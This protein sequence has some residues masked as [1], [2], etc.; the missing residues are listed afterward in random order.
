MLKKVFYLFTCFV[1]VA[2]AVFPT[3]VAAQGSTTGAG[4]DDLQAQFEAYGGNQANVAEKLPK[5]CTAADILQF[6]MNVIFSLVGGL[7]VLFIMIGGY[8]Y[9]TSGGNEELAGKGKQTVQ[10]SAIG[11]AVVLMAAALVNIVINLVVNDKLF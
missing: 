1:V 4:C 6:G 11:L 7:S 3:T 8:Q 5:Y 10:W 2:L 9:L